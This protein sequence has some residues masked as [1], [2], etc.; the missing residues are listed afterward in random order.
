MESYSLRADLGA[1]AF[2]VFAPASFLN[3][4]PWTAALEY[5]A[6]I[7][8]AYIERHNAE[9]VSTLI[10]AL[11]RSRY[12]LVSPE[13]GARR[14]AIVVIRTRNANVTAD[15]LEGELRN[16]GIHVATRNGALRL[17]PH[18]YNSRPQMERTAM[19]LNTLGWPS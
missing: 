16:A 14:S 10:S 17:S 7:G 5:V 19:V 11:D 8:T 4:V 15:E 13:C 18:F 12:E 2:D 9:L 6:Q 1:R 3:S